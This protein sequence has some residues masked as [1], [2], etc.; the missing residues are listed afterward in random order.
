[1]TLLIKNLANMVKAFSILKVF[2]MI[3]KNKKVS[4]RSNIKSQKQM[5][6]KETRRKIFGTKKKK[7][8]MKKI[9]SIHASSVVKISG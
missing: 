8:F 5:K 4:T 3:T 7:K 6:N 1:M 9:K 2:Q